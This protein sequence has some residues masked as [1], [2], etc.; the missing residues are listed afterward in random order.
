MP[1][2]RVILAVLLIIFVIG[3]ASLGRNS[4]PMNTNSMNNMNNSG[5]RDTHRST[6]PLLKYGHYGGEPIGVFN[7]TAVYKLSD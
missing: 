3:M 1:K 6:C 5:E 4:N 7:G 2:Y